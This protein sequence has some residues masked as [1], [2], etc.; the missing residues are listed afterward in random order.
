MFQITE[1]AEE[2]IRDFFKDRMDN[3]VIRVF[4]TEGPCNGPML[5]LGLSEPREGDE[6]IE[7]DGITYLIDKELLADAK[8]ITVDFEEGILR[9]GFSI[10]S[11]LELD[12][13]ECGCG[14]VY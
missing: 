10:R 5:S 1:K 2:K 6:V 13:A 9:A 12:G 3:L 8:P 11:G 4:L 7:K 14:A